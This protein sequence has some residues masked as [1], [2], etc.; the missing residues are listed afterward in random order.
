VLKFRDDRGVCDDLAAHRGLLAVV[1]DLGVGAA[2]EVLGPARA[3]QCVELVA[4]KVR[5]HRD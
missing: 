3:C 5:A 2:A 4:N 1:Q